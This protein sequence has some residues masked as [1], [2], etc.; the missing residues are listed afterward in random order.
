MYKYKITKGKSNPAKDTAWRWFSLYIRLRDC[1][2]TTGSGEYCRCVTCDAIVPYEQLD[3]GHSI[4]GRTN[5]VLFDETIVYAQCRKCNQGGDGEKIAFKNKLVA[6][7]G[8]SW[9]NQKVANRKEA[10]SLSEESLRLISDN[11]R[12]KYRKLK[13]SI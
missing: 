8:E 2:A 13:D 5:G 6:M 4:S 9:Y 1:L 11:Y 12:M 10:T 7:H 3:A